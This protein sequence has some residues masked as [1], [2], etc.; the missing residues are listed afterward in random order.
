MELDS[1]PRWKTHVGYGALFF[2]SY[3]TATVGAYLVGRL[4]GLILYS[5]SQVE[6]PFDVFGDDDE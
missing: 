3:A 5:L 6:D 4:A 2:A 1:I